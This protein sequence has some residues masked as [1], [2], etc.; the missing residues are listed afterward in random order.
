MRCRKKINEGKEH[1]YGEKGLLRD[2]QALD[3]VWN[4]TSMNSLVSCKIP[5][6]SC[7]VEVLQWQDHWFDKLMFYIF[8]RLLI[9]FSL[10][11]SL[12]LTYILSV[13]ILMVSL[14]LELPATRYCFIQACSSLVGKH[15]EQTCMHNTLRFRYTGFL[16]LKVTYY[17]LH[18][19]LAMILL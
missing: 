3:A 11:H 6:C 8:S 1:R 5:V 10:F 2:T 17:R 14:Y 9:S 12:F 13:N 15:S 16:V 7:R 19:C 18:P 4:R